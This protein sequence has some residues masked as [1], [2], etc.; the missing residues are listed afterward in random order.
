M[1]KTVFFLICLVLLV[2][3]SWYVSGIAGAEPYHTLKKGVTLRKGV[4][5]SVPESESWSCGDSITID[6]ATDDGITPS[7]DY[8]GEI[9]YGT[10]TFDFGGT[11][12]EKCMITR[13][14]GATA[15]AGSVNDGTDAAAG[16][17]WQFDN[18]QGYAVGPI[19]S[20]GTYGAGDSWVQANDPCYLLFGAGWHV[21]TYT[22]WNDIDSSKGW[23]NWNGPYDALATDSTTKLKLHAAGYL[24]SASGALGY[25]G[26][27]GIC[28][29]G[30]QSS[31]TRGWALSV[32]GYGSDMSSVAKAF[33]LSVR[34]LK[35]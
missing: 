19:P 10:A 15:Q 29:S 25:R 17:Y 9:T 2:L 31:G 13:N 4:T 24:G 18:K 33:G 32:S 21:P 14:L 7:S 12:G 16:W 8:A 35:D 22:N 23:V 1:P 27:G 28:W 20:W 11:T 5:F 26:G 6:H 30:T 3:G 34:C